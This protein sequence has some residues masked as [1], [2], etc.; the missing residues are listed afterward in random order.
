MSLYHT[1]GLPPTPV[2]RYL[3][4]VAGTEVLKSSPWSR[5]RN[6]GIPPTQISTD[7]LLLALQIFSASNSKNSINSLLGDLYRTFSFACPLL[8]S[9]YQPAMIVRLQNLGWYPHLLFFQRRMSQKWRTETLWIIRLGR[10]LDVLNGP[11]RIQSQAGIQWN[12]LEW[13]NHYRK[14]V[15]S[16]FWSKQLSAH[17]AHGSKQ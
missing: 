1:W 10:M 14:L 6:V 2:G 3:P 15:E 5:C 8:F 4:S 11:L 7:S 16:G 9:E 13:D 17:L 12:F